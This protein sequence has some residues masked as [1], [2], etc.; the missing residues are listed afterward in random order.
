MKGEPSQLSVEYRSALR[1]VYA[2]EERTY[3]CFYL[4]AGAT[5]LLLPS[6]IISLW[7][8]IDHGDLSGGFGIGSYLAGLTSSI[9]AVASYMHRSS[10]R[11]WV[12]E[13]SLPIWMV[14]DSI[15]DLNA[16]HGPYSYQR[17]TS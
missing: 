10:C 8:P 3:T 11:C 12:R 16:V 15:N 4:L 2:A 13:R 17:I 9:V 14:N 6:V 7:W 1:A 5:L